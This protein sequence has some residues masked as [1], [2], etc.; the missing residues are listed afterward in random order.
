MSSF[1]SISVHKIEHAGRETHFVNDFG[2]GIGAHRGQFAR[3][4]YD[5][6]EW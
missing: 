1:V 2:K 5:L 3:L 4:R 6:R